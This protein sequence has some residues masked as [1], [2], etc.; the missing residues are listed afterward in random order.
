MRSRHPA[1][2]GNRNGEDEWAG[3]RDDEH[4]QSSRCIP[5]DEPRAIY[6][7]LGYRETSV[8]MWKI[9]DLDLG[10]R[11]IGILGRRG[12]AELALGSRQFGEHLSLDTDPAEKR[13]LIRDGLVLFLSWRFDEV[14]L[15]GGRR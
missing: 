15:V 7:S 3:R 12:I 2:N 9:S 11:R 14:G 6:S 10:A 8:R 4:S 5:A 1:D 13:A